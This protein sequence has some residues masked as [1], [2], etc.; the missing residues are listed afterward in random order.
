MIASKIL[1]GITL[2]ISKTKFGFFFTDELKGIIAVI[3]SFNFMIFNL[4]LSFLPDMC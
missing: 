3:F 2:L 4:F 1:A